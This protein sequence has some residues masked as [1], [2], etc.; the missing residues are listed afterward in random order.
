MTSDLN[1]KINTTNNE[2]HMKSVVG[3]YGIGVRNEGRDRFLDFC[4]ENNFFI[5]NTNFKYH[6]RGLYTGLS[7]CGQ[8]RNKIEY[9]LVRN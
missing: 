5:K 8:Y 7:L 1:A 6:I 3:K 4:I 2:G 9:I